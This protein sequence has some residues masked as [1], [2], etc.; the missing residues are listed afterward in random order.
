MSDL[1]IKA[2]GLGKKD[3]I[4]TLLKILSRITESS[5]GRMARHAL[6]S[7]HGHPIEES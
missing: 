1:V 6:W 4:G 2:E 3:L 5:T 7:N